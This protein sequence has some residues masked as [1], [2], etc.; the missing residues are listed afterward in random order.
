MIDLE[1]EVCPICKAKLF[2]DEIAYCPECGAPHHKKCFLELGHCF[3]EDKHGTPEQWCEPKEKQADDEPKAQNTEQKAQSDE[4]P[5]AHP[6][7]TANGINPQEK[8]DG[9]TAEEIAKFTSYNALRYIRKFKGFSQGKRASWNWLAFLCPQYWLIARKCYIPAILIGFYEVLLSVLATITQPIL[10]NYIAQ[11]MSGNLV[12]IPNSPVFFIMGALSWVSIIISVMF[13][14]FGDYIY[15]KKVYS[16][17]KEMH[18]QNTLSEMDY[19]K[20]GGVNIVLPFLLY[21]GISLIAQFI[22]FII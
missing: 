16:D 15:K 5:K 13:G 12:T 22:L 6:F 19:V 11:I 7:F 9:V 18:E 8:I 2:V 14:I 1:K 17:I 4:Q 10:D 20:R 3:Y 21:F